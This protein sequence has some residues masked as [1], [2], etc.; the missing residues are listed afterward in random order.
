MTS[1]HFET[2]S[3]AFASDTLIHQ[4]T[5]SS[6]PS[7]SG[8]KTTQPRFNFQPS[9]YSVVCGRGK[10]SFNHIGNL[11]FRIL[12]SLFIERYSQ[13]DKKGAKSGIVS[14]IIK[15]IH[16]AGGTFCTYETGAWFE[17][18]DHR[19]RGKVSC[20]LRDLLH[21]K[22]R[23]SAKAKLGRRRKTVKQKKHQNQPSGQK[24]VE[25]TGDSDDFSTTSSCWGRSKNSLGFEYWLEE[26]D[27]FFDIDVF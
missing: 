1:N 12:A 24:R 15:V 18:E 17:V 22:Y 26:P 25:G 5:S 20:L 14:E 19:A 10:D 11:R 27:D 9:D 6:E 8:S 4:R 13:A 2:S 23:S 7:A 3:G 16:Q 21:T